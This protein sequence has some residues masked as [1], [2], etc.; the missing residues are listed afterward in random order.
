M[1]R[2]HT[3]KHFEH[4]LLHLRE[5]VLAMGARV[6]RMVGGTVRA[7]IERNASL[8]EEM[9]D[10]D[11]EVDRDEQEID[12]ICIRLL[13]QRQPVATD[14]RFITLC[15]KI[16]TDLERMGDLAVNLGE[17]A[18]ELL[19]EPLLKPLIDLPRMGERA[20]AMVRTAL[21]ALVEGD[22]DKAQ[23]V[24]E[25]DDYVDDLYESIFRELISYIL[26]DPK[27][28]KRAIGLLFAAKHLERIA[29]H[30]TNVAEMVIFWVKGKDVRHG[31][32]LQGE[33]GT[34]S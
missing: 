23:Q 33:Q 12:E 29:D 5:R 7:L 3:S 4:E 31:A 8:A 16:V 19:E 14:L 25:A 20:Q 30:A 6:E 1:M 24:L 28:A 34:A 32:A 13:A 26:E 9:I 27:S 21:D 10:L 17:R 18:L 22:P 2:E 11:K 15:M